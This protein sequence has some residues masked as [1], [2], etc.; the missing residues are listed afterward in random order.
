MVILDLEV[1]R[2]GI[3]IPTMIRKIKGAV[4]LGKG[5]RGRCGIILSVFCSVLV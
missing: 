1:S 4:V 5:E 2:D 3:F